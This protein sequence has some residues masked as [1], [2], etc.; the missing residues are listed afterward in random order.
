MGHVSREQKKEQPC[1]VGGEERLEVFLSFQGRPGSGWWWKMWLG[2]GGGA[3]QFG[4][5]EEEKIEKIWQKNAG[6]R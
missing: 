1:L 6:Q 5:Q 3:S 4:G 2:R